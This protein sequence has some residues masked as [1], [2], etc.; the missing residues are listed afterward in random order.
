VYRSSAIRAALEG[1]IPRFAAAVRNP[2][3]LNGVGG[4]RVADF[5]STST[6]VAL[7]AMF[8]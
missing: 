4:L 3:V 1:L 8:S 5:C 7:S 6:T 2:V